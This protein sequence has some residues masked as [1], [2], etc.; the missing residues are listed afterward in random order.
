MRQPRR[1]TRHLL[2]VW[3]EAIFTGED[4]A[5]ILTRVMPLTID[6]D[7]AGN[8]FLLHDPKAVELVADQGVR[9]Q[10]AA[11]VLW[12]VLGLHVPVTLHSVSVLLRPEIVKR[13]EGETLVIEHADFASVPTSSTIA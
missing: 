5:R 9:L 11:N 1:F 6:I 3:T 2:S 8:H 7:D 13:A 10:C 4:L 12:T